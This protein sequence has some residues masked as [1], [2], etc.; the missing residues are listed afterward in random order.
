V[1]R[2]L[3]EGLYKLSGYL[4][5]FFLLSIALSIIA[6]V[7]GRFVG[8]TIDATELAGFCL[9]ATTFLGLAFALRGGSH[10]RVN[11]LIRNFR[12]PTW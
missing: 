12:G 10:V 4:A 11:L 9:A 5:G 1:I 6:Q 2:T 3:L 8:L 7:V